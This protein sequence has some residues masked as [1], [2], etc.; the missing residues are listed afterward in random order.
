[1]GVGFTS[2]AHQHKQ[3]LMT[4]DAAVLWWWHA[5]RQAI[6]EDWLLGRLKLGRLDAER[7]ERGHCREEG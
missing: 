2:G 6:A 1:M 7:L 4:A 3:L 5:Y